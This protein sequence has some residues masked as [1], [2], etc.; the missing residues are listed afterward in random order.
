MEKIKE[1]ELL[2]D[3]YY[4]KLETKSQIFCNR[5]LIAQSGLDKKIV[6]KYLSE[7]WRS[8]NAKELA[9]SIQHHNKNMQVKIYDENTTKNSLDEIYKLDLGKESNELAK[10]IVYHSKKSLEQAIKED[11]VVPMFNAMHL[12]K[13]LSELSINAT[14]KNIEDMS[15]YELEEHIEKA[16]RLQNEANIHPAIDLI[17]LDVEVKK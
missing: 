2:K 8:P 14:D 13:Q 1:L 6:E 5:W 17:D 4:K 16:K 9:N 7:H 3:E 15:P 12:V 11:K 10:L